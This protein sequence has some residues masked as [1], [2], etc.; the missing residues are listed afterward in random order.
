MFL[1]EVECPVFFS[2]SGHDEIVPSSAVR[3]YV[4]LYHHKCHHN[5]P[6]FQEVKGSG[7]SRRRWRWRRRRNAL[8]M[9]VL[10]VVV[11]PLPLQPPPLLLLLPL[12]PLLPLLKMMVKCMCCV[13]VTPSR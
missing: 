8:Y 9:V 11:S 1:E 13:A 3:D 10:N 12:L 5:I 6:V 2:L 7:S 4:H